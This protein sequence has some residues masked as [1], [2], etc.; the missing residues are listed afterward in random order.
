M[1]AISA[2]RGC[3][4]GPIIKNTRIPDSVRSSSDRILWYYV[5]CTLYIRRN[6]LLFSFERREVGKKKEKIDEVQLTL[7]LG[8]VLGN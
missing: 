5:V 1:G 2:N 7:L 4:A 8:T 3:L 6:L